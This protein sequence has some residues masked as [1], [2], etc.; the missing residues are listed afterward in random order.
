MDFSKIKR[1]AQNLLFPIECLGCSKEDVWL[2]KTCLAKLKFNQNYFINKN[3]FFSLDGVFVVFDYQNKLVEK[4]IKNFKYNLV[5]DIG[6]ILGQMACLFLK[7]VEEEIDL[8]NILIIPVPLHKK[9][10]NW[11]GFN[12]A[13][14]IAQKISQKSKA[15]LEKSLVRTK[16]NQ[17]QAN[18][19][20]EKRKGN[21]AN[22]FSWQGK[23]LNNQK[24]LLID[25]IYTTG[26]TLDE[27]AKTLKEAG[28][29]KVY[30]LVMAHG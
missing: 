28:A 14:I 21:V 8:K 22:S 20:K 26:S 24:I 1:I 7:K 16:N 29:E 27:C 15:K 19:D 2:C 4:L 12:Q 6:Q 18:L 17:P 3:A 23:S 13:E 10:K 9:R 25:D 30:G 11:R 5:K